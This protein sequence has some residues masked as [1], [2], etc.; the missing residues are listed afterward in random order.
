[1]GL[2]LV[3]MGLPNFCVYRVYNFKTKIISFSVSLL[4]SLRCHQ[5]LRYFR[6]VVCCIVTVHYVHFI[7]KYSLFC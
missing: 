7:Y 5:L 3:N 6:T 1:M 2:V 4:F